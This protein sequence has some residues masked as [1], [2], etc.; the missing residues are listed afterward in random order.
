MTDF[1]IQI[2]VRNGRLL[3]AIRGVSDST[4]DF[5]RKAGVN[6]SRVG[7]LLT[8]KFSPINKNGDWKPI[9]HEICSYVGCEPDLLWPQHMQR[10]LLKRSEA[11]V[12]M[13]AAEVFAIAGDADTQMTHR[14]LLSHAV[15]RLTPREIECIGRRQR[16]ETLEQIA[17]DFKVTGNR[18]GQI[19]AKAY[20]KMKAAS[21]RQGYRTWED[22]V[23]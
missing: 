22:V 15:K 16:G 2:R 1:N 19:E 5:C 9:V 23:A 8:M 10:M 14:A 17:V 3:R 6:Q 13:S 12:D 7:A 4:A 18:V 20:R 21:F 11:E